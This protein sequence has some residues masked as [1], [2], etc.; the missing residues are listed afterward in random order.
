MPDKTLL[1]TVCFSS[2]ITGA[3]LGILPLIPAFMIWAAVILMFSVS[4]FII[5]YLKKLNIL[6]T[7]EANKVITVSAIAGAFAVFGFCTIYLPV[8][9]ILNLIFK[10]QSFLWVKVAFINFGF[11]IPMIL[12][13]ALLSA[14]LNAFSGFVTL[15]FINMKK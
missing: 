2:F 4:P 1:K 7:E 9:L 6:N 12:F 15:Y 10:I 3:V 8:A 13:T 11:M 5:I 14:L